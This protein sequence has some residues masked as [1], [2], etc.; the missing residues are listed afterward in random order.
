MENTT[1]IQ[2]EEQHK[3]INFTENKIHPTAIIG[4]DV[5]MGFGN[6]IGAYVVITGKVSIGN[7]NKFES[8]C[9]IGSEPEHK[10][11][12][13][14][15][16]S[17]TIIGSN[18]IFRE[19]VTINAGCETPTIVSN[20]VIMLRGSHCGHD[21]L[22]DTNCTISCNVLIGGHS[23]IGKEANLGLGAILHQF[24]KIGCF[25]MVGMGTIVTKKSIIN[26]FGTYVGNPAK[27]IKENDYKKKT[28][29]A[30]EIRHLI[31]DYEYN[32][33]NLFKP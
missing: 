17:G 20:D 13:G 19:Y 4:A 32:V 2:N 6:E 5:K 21:A 11:Y 10:G 9:V 26:P 16:N 29:N 22:I 30:D 31:A 1:P 25:A 23:Y 28:F 14:K 7:N 27:Y 15:R 33:E 24:S 12:F 8:F 3:D 18:N